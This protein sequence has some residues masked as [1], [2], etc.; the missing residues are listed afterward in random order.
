MIEILTTIIQDVDL[1]Q[2]NQKR[3]KDVSNFDISKH[4]ALRFPQKI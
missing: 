3:A 4:E 2:T 1:Q